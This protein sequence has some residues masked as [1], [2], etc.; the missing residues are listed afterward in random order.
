MKVPPL[1]GIRY[2]PTLVQVSETAEECRG[3]FRGW[4]NQKER[5]EEEKDAK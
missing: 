4:G 3:N 5:T 2:G 1:G